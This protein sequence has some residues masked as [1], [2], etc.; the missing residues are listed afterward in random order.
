M[1]YLLYGDDTYRSWAKLQSIKTKYL[2]ASMGDTDLAILEGATVTADQFRNQIQTQPFLARNRLVIVRN[3]IKEGKKEVHEGI[4]EELPKLPKTTI[5]FF[6]EAG[7]PDKRTKLFQ[8][9]NQPKQAQ[10]FPL[11]TGYEL[12]KYVAEEAKKQGIALSSKAAT[13]LTSITGPDLWRL[14]QELAKLSLYAKNKEI[15]EA[16]IDLL[17]GGSPEVTIFALTD[18]FGQRD[19]KTALKLLAQFEAEDNPLGLLAMIASHFRNLLLIADGQRLNYPKPELS[20]ALK[21]HPF[22]FDKAFAQAH[23][24]TF[25][26]LKN[27]YHY[28]FQL[29]LLAKQSHI[30]P[31]VG[32]T[33]LASCLDQKTIQLPDLTEEKMI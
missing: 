8:T 28:L 33:I 3:V 23:G 20:K 6:Y 9:L 2:D 1:I 29:D 25:K 10:E 7:Q 17:V 19:K 13:Y 14:E 11:L 12:I 5:L 22:V 31:Y 15:T 4:I 27:I 32:L 18:A 30:D 24:Y 26:E 16:D 21:L